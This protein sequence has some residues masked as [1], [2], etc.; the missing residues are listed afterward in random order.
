MLGIR[1]FIKKSVI[2]LEA[3]C[4]SFEAH[5]S[6]RALHFFIKSLRMAINR[7]DSLHVTALTMQRLM[8]DHGLPCW[9]HDILLELDRLSL[10]DY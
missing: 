5:T 2:L 7:L 6:V 8:T 4:H 3:Y 1:V 9:G 10:T